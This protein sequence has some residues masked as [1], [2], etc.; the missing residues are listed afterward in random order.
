[1]INPNFDLENE[2]MAFLISRGFKVLAKIYENDFRFFF[3]RGSKLL[4]GFDVQC[5][6]K[7]LNVI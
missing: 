3:D 6:I 7:I 5:E 2:K 1:M 4:I